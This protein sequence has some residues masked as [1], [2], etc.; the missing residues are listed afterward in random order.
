M[1]GE[2]LAEYRRLI[3]EL[4]RNREA[5]GGLLDRVKQADGSL[6]LTKEAEGTWDRLDKEY[7]RDRRALRKLLAAKAAKKTSEK[8]AAKASGASKPAAS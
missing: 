4:K 5:L 6:K 1:D 3:G 7:S 2:I 8:A